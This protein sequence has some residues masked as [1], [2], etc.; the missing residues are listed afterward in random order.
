MISLNILS[1]LSQN[2]GYLTASS[3]VI[4]RYTKTAVCPTFSSHADFQAFF[5]ATELTLVAMMLVYRTGSRTSTGISKIPSYTAFKERLTSLTGENA[6]VLS[7]A[8]V[9]TDSTFDWNR[10]NTSICI[11]TSCFTCSYFRSSC[12][13]RGSFTPRDYGH[14][15][16]AVRIQSGNTKRRK[17]K[18]WL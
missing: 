9:T 17:V 1:V 14:N 3:F 15:L 16:A 7:A 13:L 4:M 5:Q 10:C 12:R 18:G 6:I 11:G 8:F 2:I